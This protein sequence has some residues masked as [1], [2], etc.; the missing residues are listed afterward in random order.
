MRNFEFSSHQTVH[1]NNLQSH[2]QTKIIAQRLLRATECNFPC[3]V[4]TSL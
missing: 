3:S 4:L 1:L 2:I